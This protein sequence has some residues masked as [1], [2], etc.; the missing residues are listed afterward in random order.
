MTAIFSPS[1]LQAIVTETL[2]ALPEGHT[3][4]I[5]GL[6]T[7]TGVCVVARFKFHNDHWAVLAAAEHRWDGLDTIGATVMLSW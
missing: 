6:V 4:A 3:S 5:V 7:E 1:Q 2:P